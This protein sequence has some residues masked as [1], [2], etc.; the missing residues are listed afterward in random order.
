MLTTMYITQPGES[1][2]RRGIE[3]QD[4]SYAEIIR[5]PRGDYAVSAIADGVGACCYS[6]DGSRLAVEGSVAKLRACLTELEAPLDEDGML[7]LLQESFRYALDGIFAEAERRCLSPVLMETTLTVGVYEAE[8]RRL[9]YGHCGDGGIVALHDNAAY[10]LITK[11]HKGEAQN[12]VRPLR[13]TAE[14]EFGVEER[15]AACA[16][17]TDG[18][19]DF[20]VGDEAHANR[21]Y[22]P[23]F[24]DALLFRAE[25]GEDAS[26]E[27]DAWEA[28]L[29]GVDGDGGIRR[30]VEDDMTL[31]VIR[32]QDALEGM[33]EVP[34]DREAWEQQTLLYQQKQEE[35]LYPE[36]A[37]CYRAGETQEAA[38]AS[39]REE[40]GV[41]RIHD[42]GLKRLVRRMMPRHRIRCTG[43]VSGVR[44]VCGPEPVA[45]D[46]YQTNHPDRFIRLTQAMSGQVREIVAGLLTDLPGAEEHVLIDLVCTGRE[47]CIGYVFTTGGQGKE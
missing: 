41:A 1:H 32:N 30:Y 20:S 2:I 29:S 44:Y 43:L 40:D 18:L 12:I 15:V 10:A 33:G 26:K 46:V 24:R 23:F 22:W 45:Q 34:F 6:G 21:V 17:L 4:A 31:L 27:K 8:T 36:Y 47:G 38:D 25:T 3:C 5:T 16:M 42:R 14:W 19:L 35:A 13:E 11:R 9:Y 39:A 28:R 7:R 37:A